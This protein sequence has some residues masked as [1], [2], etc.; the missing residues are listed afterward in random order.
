MYFFCIITEQQE[1]VKKC[2]AI[3][4]FDHAYISAGLW[5]FLSYVIIGPR[6]DVALSDIDQI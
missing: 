4:Q 2:A 5:C 6:T 3:G 1:V